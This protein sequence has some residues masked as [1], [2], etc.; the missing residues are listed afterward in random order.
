MW[1]HM[2]SPWTDAFVHV[3][4]EGLEMNRVSSFTKELPPRCFHETKCR[5]KMHHMVRAQDDLKHSS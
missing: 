2:G 1:Q 3:V 5:M 4:S